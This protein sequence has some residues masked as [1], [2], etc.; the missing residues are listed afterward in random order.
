MQ[1]IAESKGGKCLSEKYVINNSK[2][3][4]QCK[5]GQIW[6]AVPDSIVRRT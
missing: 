4:W 2:L 6:D 3:K 5:E 1:K